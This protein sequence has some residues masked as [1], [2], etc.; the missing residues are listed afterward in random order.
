MK[1]LLIAAASVALLTALPAQAADLAA[2]AA[3]LRDKA[4]TDPTAWTV[5]ES[6]TTEVGARQV[7]SPYAGGYVPHVPVDVEID[8]LGVAKVKLAARRLYAAEHLPREAHAGGGAEQASSGDG[9]AQCAQRRAMSS[10]VHSRRRSR[11]SS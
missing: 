4:L 8:A 6:L 9:P 10:A 7:G 1:N 2:T 3:S 5:L 11:C